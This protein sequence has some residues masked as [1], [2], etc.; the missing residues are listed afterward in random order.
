[1]PGGAG[2]ALFESGR[3][4]F[5]GVFPELEAELTGLCGDGRYEGPGGSPD[6]ADAMVWAL[7]RLKLSGGAEPRV[8]G[9]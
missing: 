5:A 9:L 8:R 1:V 6:R 7:T 4:K 3:A 2:G